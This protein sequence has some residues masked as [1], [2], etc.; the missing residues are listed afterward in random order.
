M[1]SKPRTRVDTDSHSESQRNDKHFGDSQPPI[2]YKFEQ[3]RM[4][5]LDFMWM[6]IIYFIKHASNPKFCLCT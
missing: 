1:I 4:I 5:W 3:T 2:L 6:E